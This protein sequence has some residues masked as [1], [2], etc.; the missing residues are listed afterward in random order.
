MKILHVVEDFSVDG[1]GLRAA[2][3]KLNQYLNLQGLESY[4][5]SAKKEPE[6]DIFIVESWGKW[7]YSKKWNTTI[8]TIVK[9]K[10]INLIHIHGVWLFPQFITAKYAI[11]NE[12]P[13]VLS[14]HGMLQPRLWKK[15]TLKK[16]LYFE[17]LI[18]G[19]FLNASLIHNI[20]TNEGQNLKK[21][22]PKKRFIEIPNLVS[23]KD[24]LEIVK[25]EKYILYLGRLNRTKGID[26][27]IKAFKKLEK[28]EFKLK[29]AGGT[30][31]YRKELKSLVTKF[32]LTKRVEFL[33]V[34]KSEE[35]KRI[36]KKAW[37][38]AAPTYSD[39][40]GIVN[41]EAASLRTPMITTNETGLNP[42]WNN[43][44]GRLINPTVRELERALK[45]AVDW[46]IEERT[47][48]GNKL[49]EF[50]KKFYSWESRINDWEMLYKQVFDDY[51]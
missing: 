30:N 34:V 23:F 25:P 21:Y 26:L 15:G 50:A 51:E 28:N 41:L 42:E 24:C 11:E 18:K 3:K 27:L 29:I 20:T 40:I 12:I 36:I 47:N 48:H 31:T 44:G 17:I 2:V 6:D 7:L 37:V 35:K 5:L 14:T 39:V 16:K 49:Y 19:K 43:N 33:G 9:D 4:V 38:M 46:T 22:F 32:D 8:K 10:N 45:E 13:F 1:G